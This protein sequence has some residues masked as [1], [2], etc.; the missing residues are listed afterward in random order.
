MIT[1]TREH[2]EVWAAIDDALHRFG[3]AG[4]ELVGGAVR[5]MLLDVYPKDLDFATKSIPDEVFMAMFAAGFSVHPTGL[6]HGT[7]TAVVHGVPVEITT[8]RRDVETDGRHAR[9]EFVD[10]RKEDARRRD[11][12]I[13]AMYMQRNGVV[14]DYFDGQKDLTDRKIRFVGDPESR[15]QEDYLRILRYFRFLARF[16]DAVPDAE[17]LR[18]ITLHRSG[19]NSIAGERIWKELV[20]LF[21]GDN[22]VEAVR[23]MQESGVIDHVSRI[24]QIT[25]FTEGKFS[26][27]EMLNRKVPP[28]VWI[29]QMLESVED[30]GQL[31]TRLK[32]DN[33]SNRLMKEII[34]RRFTRLDINVARKMLLKGYDVETL[35]VLALD[36]FHLPLLREL[37]RIE[38]EP[39]PKFP[40]T[41]DDIRAL[42]YVGP[43]IGSIIDSLKD[44]FV[45]YNFLITKEELL[46]RLERKV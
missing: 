42:G 31:R 45:D 21:S 18:A 5:D 10:D 44:I 13:N 14:I 37:E 41:G 2:K 30:L 9:V 29:A 24:L 15:I 35:K 23:H 22:C 16:A 8:W 11:L 34:E 36:K 25:H 27:F 19:L 32:F 33:A 20:G 46:D 4:V 38:K 43:G 3:Y 6:E 26:I 1:L 39:L 17:S 7:V 12:T 28:E 40:I